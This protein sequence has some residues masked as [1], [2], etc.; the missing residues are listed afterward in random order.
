MASYVAGEFSASGIPHSFLFGSQHK[1]LLILVEPSG[2]LL[3]TDE[4]QPCLIDFS[5]GVLF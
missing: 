1:L 5:E 4:V 3:D 2:F